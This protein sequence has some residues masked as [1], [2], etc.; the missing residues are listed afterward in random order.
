MV[1]TDSGFWRLSFFLY[2]FGLKT[3][4]SQLAEL[5]FRRKTTIIYAERLGQTVKCQFPQLSGYIH[6]IIY[7]IM[8][9]SFSHDRGKKTRHENCIKSHCEVQ[10]IR[11]SIR[12]PNRLSGDGWL[13]T[14]LTDFPSCS[15]RW[16]GAV[17]I[18]KCCTKC[19]HRHGWRLT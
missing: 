17:E 18:A 5:H 14:W 9:H 8:Q 2:S 15:T 6:T 16:Y 13:N 19:W 11:T 12:M 7:L 10:R 4:A 3:P 1:G